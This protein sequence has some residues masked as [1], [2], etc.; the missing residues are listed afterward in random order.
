[1]SLLRNKTF[2][3]LAVLLVLG[4]ALGVLQ[5][6]TVETG[7][8]YIVQDVV[9]TALMPVNVASHYLLAAGEWALRAGRPRSA[10]LRENAELRQEVR[11]LTREN[12]QL[13]EDAAECG[14]LRAALKLQETSPLNMVAAE[15]ISRNE[16]SWFDTATINRGR[17]SGVVQG[18]AVVNHRGLI[19]QIM[20]AQPF[21]SQ[22]VTLTDPNSA[23]GGVVQRSRSSGIV[24]GQGADYL[25][26][27][28]LPKDADVKENDIVVSSGMGQVIPK[29]LPIGRVVRVV[30]NSLA[31]T[32]SALVRPS[33]RLDQIDKVFV[34]QTGQGALQ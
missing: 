19:G 3:V 4:T 17:K 2:L 28:Y 24:Q 13:R 8:P 11:R 6:L 29:G 25:V 22:I 20:Q 23:V 12:A 14:A 34:V 31:G 27:A 18:A 7:T 30:R 15:V 9:R 33:V 32:T 26:L 1:M 16:S 5:K 21:T 10:L